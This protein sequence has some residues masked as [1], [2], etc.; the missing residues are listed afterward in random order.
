MVID[1]VYD[2]IS[3]GWVT[4][5]GLVVHQPDVDDAAV[6]VYGVVGV[7]RV[8]LKQMR[9]AILRCRVQPWGSFVCDLLPCR[10]SGLALRWGVCDLDPWEGTL[11]LC[12]VDDG[13][14]V[15]CLLNKGGRGFKGACDVALLSTPCLV[16]ASCG[17]LGGVGELGVLPECEWGHGGVVL[18]NCFVDADV[19]ELAEANKFGRFGRLQMDG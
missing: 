19:F 1:G 10:L 17:A 2:S 4:Y 12:R 5:D 8:M 11:G 3:E 13:S 6:R 16:G 9:P 14:G 15:A 7:L 18:L